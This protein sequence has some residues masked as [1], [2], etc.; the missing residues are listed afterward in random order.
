M[1]SIWIFVSNIIVYSWENVYLE[2]KESMTS[3]NVVTRTSNL[4][5]KNV[6]V[7][8]GRFMPLS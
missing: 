7:R 2:A 6:L 4:I 1:S 5:T 8:F 3:K